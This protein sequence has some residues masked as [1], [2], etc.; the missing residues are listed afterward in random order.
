MFAK[1]LGIVL[2]VLGILTSNVVI[3]LWRFFQTIV[4][5]LS[6]FGMFNQN[7]KYFKV[8]FQECLL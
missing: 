8:L 5:Q 4:C 1:T 3:G 7:S 6:Q 2:F